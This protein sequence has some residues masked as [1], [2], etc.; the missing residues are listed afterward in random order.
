MKRKRKTKNEGKNKVAKINNDDDEMKIGGSDEENFDD[1]DGDGDVGEFKINIVKKNV[2]NIEDDDKIFGDSKEKYEKLIKELERNDLKEDVYEND[3]CFQQFEIINNAKN[4]DIYIYGLNANGN[5]VFC[6][7]LGFKPYLYIGNYNYSDEQWRI[8]EKYT[9]KCI[10]VNKTNILC[11]K[12]KPFT[13]YMKLEVNNA[14]ELNDFKNALKRV[15]VTVFEAN[16]LMETKFMIDN[17]ITGCNW[18][19][20]KNGKYKI[21][22]SEDKQSN[23][24]IE[25]HVHT[26][27]LVS[28]TVEQISEIA[29]LRTLSFDIECYNKDQHF[30]RAKLGD[31]II[32][33]GCYLH[34]IGKAEMKSVIFTLNTC[35]DINGSTVLSF[36]NEKVLLRKFRDMIISYD[37]D[38]IIGYNIKGFD[39]P[40]VVERCIELDDD[41]S[42]MLSRMKNDV[43]ITKTSV[44]S[45][46]QAGMRITKKTNIAGRITMDIM[47]RIKESEKLRSYTLNN[48]SS[49]FLGDQKEEVH[50]SEISK[51]QDAGP[52]KRKLIA[53]YCLKDS[54]LPVKLMNNRMFLIN[55][56]EMCR[57]CWVTMN[58]LFTSGQ[59]KK[60]IAQLLNNCKYKDIICPTSYLKG[61]HF[62]GALVYDPICGFY[63]RPIATLDFTSLYPSIMIG[64][65]LCYSTLIN[66]KD[67]DDFDEDDYIKT[68]IGAYFIKQHIKRGVLPEILKNLLD[69]R[70]IAKTDMNNEKDPFKKAVLYGRQLALK[71]SAN[72]V[73][74]FTNANF[75]PEPKISSSVTSIGREKILKTKELVE[76][77]VKITNGYKFNTYIIYGDTDSVMVVFCKLEWKEMFEC[78]K[79]KVKK[80]KYEDYIAYIGGEKDKF[81]EEE[82]EE[83]FEICKKVSAMI[84]N[85]LGMGLNLEFEKI[86]YPYLLLKKKKYS[87]VKWTNPKKSDGIDTKGLESV[88]RDNCKVNSETVAKVLE[89]ILIKNDI[90]AAI[91]YVKSVVK[92][93]VNKE[94]DMYY[95]IISGSFTKPIKSYDGHIAHIELVK[96][97]L[98]RDPESAPRIGDR[99]PYIIT[100]YVTPGKKAKDMKK[101]EKAESPLYVLKNNIPIDYEWYIKNQLEKPITRILEYIKEKKVIDGIFKF[102]SKKSEKLAKTSILFNYVKKKYNCYLCKKSTNKS[103]IL[104]DYCILNYDNIILTSLKMTKEISDYDKMISRCWVECQRCQNTL[105][106][107]IVCSNGDC[108]I[109]FKRHDLCNKSIELC[110]KKELF[111]LDFN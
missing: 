89:Y 8:V 78:R 44:F 77:E 30:P 106:N 61:E 42:R 87:G 63:K 12:K 86:Y 9:A 45:S 108:P 104:C 79:R 52:E 111:D 62:D 47:S 25:I 51:F 66:E 64:H 109:F 53:V 41:A 40:Y 38:I 35:D 20:A 28:H 33:I 98:K 102:Q 17:A 56:I 99:V 65:N 23:C 15:N 37:P 19:S 75:L 24:Q 11:H 10:K 36:S 26:N 32:Q 107:E 88:R 55:A 48:V 93:L 14:K 49:H 105:L 82:F 84:T 76:E 7:V 59:Q 1:D 43:S 95:L 68:P 91:E 46:K 34:E 27:H 72:S 96:K 80:N 67:L 22:E 94:I 5:S 57:V 2:K 21:I 90:N 83:I 6:T 16:V 39:I 58:I 4:N 69:A 85:K 103:K 70:K 92:Q 3:V 18:L 71:T 31:P 81:N 54:L 60:I 100:N 97:L 50:H 73:Y 101:Y 110:E 29:P 74:G 13:D